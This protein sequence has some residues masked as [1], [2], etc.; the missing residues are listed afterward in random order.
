MG[1]G[2]CRIIYS[3]I[4]HTISFLKYNLLAGTSYVKLPK[5]SEYSRKGLINIQNT[6]D[7]E[8][9]TWCLVRY[10]NP[11]N[12]NPKKKKEKKLIKVLKRDLIFK[13]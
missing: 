10:L 12:H 1:K 2:P 3:A 4:D 9:F 13:T 6:D 11:A 7:N 5:E 8:S